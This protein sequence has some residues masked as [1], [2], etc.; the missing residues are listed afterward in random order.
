M[1]QKKVITL[2][3]R[4]PKLRIQRKQRSNRRLIFYLSFFF[5]LLLTVIYFQSSLSDVKNIRI[6]GN[7]YVS[8][9][10]IITVS[11]LNER[12]SF[13]GVNKE[14]I[15]GKLRELHEI[16]DVMIER[17]FPNTLQ[18]KVNEY[19][20]VAYLVVDGKNHPILESGMI[21]EEEKAVKRFPTDAPLL[22]GWSID[23]ELAEMAAELSNLPESL[24]HRISEIYFTP[25]PEDP[26]RITL[27]MNDGFK[28]S[29]T[30]RHFSQKIASYPAIIK[31]LD[32]NI[33]GIIHMKMNPYF[34]Q[35]DNE[36]EQEIESE[37]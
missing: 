15:E 29:S 11:G 4:I 13:W 7:R 12:T 10:T 36:E 20:R 26:L 34:E 31:E 2:E 22:I 14:L 37:G 33:K 27:Y 32:P 5:V 17:I 16:N 6:D 28:V 23:E 24:I 35:F 1:D 30:V 21:L 3:D 9:E 25:V 8:D 18:I 19:A